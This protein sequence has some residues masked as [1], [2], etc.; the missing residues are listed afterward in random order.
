MAT[1]SKCGRPISAYKS[2]NYVCGLCREKLF[3]DTYMESILQEFKQ[4][5]FFWEQSQIN[6][7]TVWSHIPKGAE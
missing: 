3:P 4:E 5:N 6:G 1:C 7:Q 2:K